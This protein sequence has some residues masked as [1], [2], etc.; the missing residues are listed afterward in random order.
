[1][2]NP[3]RVAGQVTVK[4]DGQVLETDGSSTMELGGPVRTPVKGDY[5]AGAFTET[6]VEAKLE[7]SIL[8][9][10]GTSIAELRKI[11]NATCTLETDVGVTWVIRNAYCSDV[12]SVN[13]NE[14]K[15]KVVFMGPPAEELS[16]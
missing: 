14:G 12:I 11:D 16:L 10:A 15:A 7:T 2:A 13:A 8:I 3:N 4:V 5:Q 9:K 1:M 6:T